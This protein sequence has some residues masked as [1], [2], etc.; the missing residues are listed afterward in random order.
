MKYIVALAIILSSATG[1]SA[2]HTH[3]SSSSH[4]SSIPSESGQAAFAAIAEITD[5]LR[6]D[7]ETDW[8]TVNIDALREHL[9][10]MN[11]LTLSANIEVEVVPNGA[12]FKITGD[13]RT[14]LAIKAMV[15]AHAPFLG[16]ETGWDVSVASIDGGV[17][18][19][20]KGDA[21]K[22]RALG[23]SGLMSTGAHHQTHHL[24]MARGKAAH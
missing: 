22:I 3:D 20:V 12:S 5:L 24:A 1:V 19:S 15:P 7:P 23:F 4:K 21:Q 9:V 17:T 6:N 16:R 10:D 11:L 2:Q 14:T 18:M 13:P 8:S